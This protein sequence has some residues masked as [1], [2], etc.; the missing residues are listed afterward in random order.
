MKV[1]FY[2]Y[3]IQSGPARKHV[4][5]HKLFFLYRLIRSE[6][7]QL[8]IGIVGRNRQYTQCV[9]VSKTSLPSL[10]GNDS[11]TRLDYL[12]VQGIAET[13]TNAVVD[14]HAHRVRMS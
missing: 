13:E 2:F 8:E 3:V 4:K 10:D 6:R 1:L 5:V 7:L 11:G 12:H 14:L 9:R